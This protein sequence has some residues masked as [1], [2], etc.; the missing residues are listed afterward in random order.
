VYTGVCH[1]RRSDLHIVQQ[2]TNTDATFSS[3][4]WR[5]RPFTDAPYYGARVAYFTGAQRRTGI[6]FDFTHYKMYAPDE[7][8]TEVTG[9]WNGSPLRDPAALLS[10]Y[11]QGL[12][13]SHGVNL[14][15]LNVQYRRAPE[16]VAGEWIPYIGAGVAG[17]WPHAEGT[18]NSIPVSANYRRSGH[19]AQIFGGS[20][21]RL[22]A[23]LGAQLEG[24]FDAGKLDIDLVPA[25]R[26]A[27]RTRTFH[28]IAGLTWHF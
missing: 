6:T 21:Y 12:E 5:A 28:L 8:P 23:H 26:V 14:T 17:Y 20:E 19:G 11:V 10:S 3:I 2:A 24:K 18:I 16:Q 7:Q 27:T 4:D 25:T 15:S 9:R 22:T 1:T 13:I